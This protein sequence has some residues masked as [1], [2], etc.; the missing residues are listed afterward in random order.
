MADHAILSASSASRWMACPPSARLEQNYPNN[1]SPAA[2]EGTLAHELGE[3]KLKKELGIIPK[4]KYNSE[5][6]KIQGREF[7]APDMD[8]YVDRYVEICM[9]K[10]SEARATTVD[11][12]TA[13]E[14]RLNF[15]QWV[16]EGFG[17]GDMVIIGDG[18]IEIIDLKYGKGIPVSAIENKQMRLYALGAIK[19]YIFLYDIK[20]VKM[21]IVQP[22]L[23]SVS[24]DEITA[25]N[26]ML[27]GDDIVKPLAELAI[28]GEGEFC[29]GSH[30]IFCRAKAV[31]RARA[32][33][34]MELA[35]YEFA[36]KPTLS[37]EEISEILEQAEELSKWA[38]DVQSYAL[39]QA[40]QG[41]DYPGWK[42]VEGKSNRKYT[43]PGE[44]AIRLMDNEIR[45]DL[46]YK[47]E[48]LFGITQLEK[49]IGKKTFDEIVG[50]F[51]EK[52]PGKPVL[53]V[54]S[55]KRAEFNSAAK[56]FE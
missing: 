7:Y 47:P 44:I 22:R 30:C 35:K 49:N 23:D 2:A 12:M 20:N 50:T 32:D 40:M 54:E 17:T 39:E 48:E 6:K 9:E 3:L 33:K 45:S 26:L 34:N 15:S 31:C 13:I 56:D 38:K 25:F 5:Y 53:V 37:P 24:T 36:A 8:S 42:V 4:R 55:D 18:C 14:K 28:K 19:E 21:T 52:P 51:I 46:I 16:P 43:D 29:S 1:S 41:I 11:A 10:V 27:W